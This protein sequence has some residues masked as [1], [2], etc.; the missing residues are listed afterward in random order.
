MRV[1][2]LDLGSNTFLCLIVDGDMDSNGRPYLKQILSDEV[3][4]VRLGQDVDK[5]RRFHPE[6]LQRADAAL[7]EFHQK[8]LKFKPDRILAMATSAARDVENG[9][10]LFEL[11]RKYQIPIEVIPGAQEAQ[12]TYSGATSGMASEAKPVPTNLV[13]DIGGGSTEF[14]RGTGTELDWGHS[15]DLGCVRLVERLGIRGPMSAET[16]QKARAAIRTELETLPTKLMIARSDSRFN[17]DRILAVAGTPTELA[18]MEIGVFDPVKIDGY[19]FALDKIEEWFSRLAPLTAQQ[20]HT[21]FQVSPGRADVLPVGLL[22]LS[23]SLKYFGQAR[24]QVSTRGVR[25]GVAFV[26]LTRG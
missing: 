25:F 13:I 4:M 18:R 21:D 8:I 19:E 26:A 20:I 11:G 3:R 10:A 23:E 14:I 15:L 17:V 2:A 5:T 16:E 1:A 24:L 12:I 6:A 22:I 9:E 7:G